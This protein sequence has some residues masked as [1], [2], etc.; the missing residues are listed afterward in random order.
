MDLIPCERS[1]LVPI[2]CGGSVLVERTQNL[3][4]HLGVCSEQLVEK[5]A[6]R[7]GIDSLVDDLE[8]GEGSELVG[9]EAGEVGSEP[10][11][12][13]AVA[14]LEIGGVEKPGDEECAVG[15]CRQRDRVE[16]DGDGDSFL[17]QG[18]AVVE[19]KYRTRRTT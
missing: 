6:R 4:Q 1:R 10:R 11:G 9:A 15:A 14:T 12:E 16:D 19:A 5:N 17:Q 2:V 18:L 7:H 13:K 3:F 8:H